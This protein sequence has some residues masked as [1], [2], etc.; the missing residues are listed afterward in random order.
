MAIKKDDNGGFA[1]VDFT[2][3]VLNDEQKKAQAVYIA[4]SRIDP[5]KTQSI[6]NMAKGNLMSPGVLTSL[7]ALGVAPTSQL[8]KNIAGIDQQTKDVRNA[9]QNAL[10]AQRE[11][12]KFN[13][14]PQGKLWT[15]VK[16]VS[17]GLFAVTGTIGE[18]INAAYRQAAK[19]ITDR[20]V[21]AG[22]LRPVNIFASEKDKEE[23]NRQFLSQTKVGQVL[24][25]ALDNKSLKGIDAGAGF[26]VAEDTGIGKAARDAA[27]ATAKID[28]KNA[29]GEVIGSRPRSFFS[30]APSYILSHGHPDGNVG[31]VVQFVTD[32]AASYYTDPQTARAKVAKL[33]RQA[34]EAA[35]AGAGLKESSKI[36]DDLQ[37][38]QEAEKKVNEARAAALQAEADLKKTEVNSN[39][40]NIDEARKTWSGRNEAKIAATENVARKNRNLV[41]AQTK[42]QAIKDEVAGIKSQLDEISNVAKAPNRLAREE[43]NLA[44]AQKALETAK[45][46]SATGKYPT[47][48]YDIPKLETAVTTAQKTVDDLRATVSAATVPDITKIEELKQSLNAALLRAKLSDKEVKQL[49]IDLQSAKKGARIVAKAE[50]ANLI[51]YGNKLSKSRTAQEIV[52]D[53]AATYETKLKAFAD[54]LESLSGIKSGAKPEVN[55]DSISQ[56]LTN[57]HGSAAIDRLAEI[58]D[59]KQIFRMG[60]GRVS[61]EQAIDIAKA[62]TKEEVLNKLAPYIADASLELGV[63][64]PGFIERTGATMAERTKFATPLVKSL[65]GAGAAVANRMPFHA[66]AAAFYEGLADGFKTQADTAKKYVFD[67]IKR[68]Y[69]TTVRGGALLNIHDT[70][71]LIQHVDDAAQ[72]LKL[73]KSV[74]DKLMERIVNAKSASERGYIATVEFFDAVFKQ[75]EKTLPANVTKEFE[76]VTRQ[77]KESNNKAAS[78]W[79]SRNVNGADIKFIQKGGEKV[80]LHGPHLESE[81]LNST[82]YFPAVGEVNRFLGKLQKYSGLNEAANITDALINDY[83][84]RLQLARPAYIIRNIAEEQL[85]VF[86]TGHISF[87]NNPMVATAMWLGAKEGSAFRKAL[88]RIDNYTHTVI[89]DTFESGSAADDLLDEMAAH[90]LK[91]SYID[92]M[93]KSDGSFDERSLRVLHLKSVRAVGPEHERFWDGIVNQMRILGSDTMARVVAGSTPPSVKAAI[94]AGKSREDAVVE[95]FLSGPGRKDLDILA[96]HHPEETR[97]WL[98]SFDGLKQYLYTGKATVKGVVKDASVMSR[99]METTAGNAN[100]RQLIAF[101]KT[102]IGTAEL[103][104]PTAADSASNSLRNAKAIREGKKALLDEQEKFAKTIKNAFGNVAKHSEDMEVNI[105]DV[106]V[107]VAAPLRILGDKTNNAFNW[108]FDTATAFE[109]NSTMGPEFRQAYWDAIHNVASALDKNAIAKLEAMAKDSLSPLMKNGENIGKSHPVWKALA[110]ASEDGVLSL[111]DAH[112]YADNYARNHVKDLF[113]TANKRRLLFHQLRLIGPFMSA[114]EDTITKWGKIGL[115]NPYQVYNLG[116]AINWLEKPESSAMYRFTDIHD[117]YDP[118]QGFFFTDAQT[119]QRMFW[120]PFAGTIM[121]KIAGVPANANYNGNPIAYAANPMSFNFAL[122]AGSILPGV[123]PGITVPLTALDSFTGII[124][125][126]PLPI[127]KWLFPFGKLDLSQGPLSVALPNNINR[128]ITGLT[129]ED[130]LYSNTYKPI[131]DYIASGGNYNLDDVND[132]AELLK[133]TDK[134]AG[135]LSVMRGVVGMF[136]PAALVNKALTHDQNG[137]VTTQIALYNDFRTML[138]ANNNDYNTTVHDFLDLYGANAVFSIISGTSG[139]GPDNWDSYQF[140]VQNP[141]VATKYSDVWGYVYPGGGFS[142]EMYKWNTLNKTKGKLSAQ[143]ILDKANNLRYYAAKDGIIKMVDAGKLDKAGY[144][145]A[146]Q[147]LNNAFNGGPKGAFDPKKFSREMA[148]MRALVQDPRFLDAPSIQ[149]LR[150]YLYLRDAA[151]NKIGVNPANPFKGTGDNAKWAK[152]WLSGQVNTLLRDNPDFYKFYYQFFAKELEG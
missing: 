89:G 77:F 66:Q 38:A 17:R 7:S 111:E 30:D 150:D 49:T 114:W 59:W 86:G 135:F 85:R 132:Q 14:T 43:S 47:W 97:R 18:T 134:F 27:N 29:K 9:N 12:E 16:G 141:D 103:R 96:N 104:M 79:A 120:V 39:K 62:T 93:A 35:R 45:A 151:L 83:W 10:A 58:T 22:L 94:A 108:F 142:Q 119:G 128:I 33:K 139:K 118:N 1:Q 107:D 15:A 106:N 136:S 123:G 143:E 140:V 124:D 23:Y 50:E 48:M 41:D 84:K 73:D 36:A 147:N 74:T 72:V 148:Q 152:T 6:V 20:G 127:Q 91:N 113:Y 25:Q 11:T 61:V 90:N 75:Y 110:N 101:G 95:Y 80:V 126:L 98:Q 64:K 82:V 137:D 149:A 8:S 122:G 19:D 121:S 5:V 105:P 102:K 71:A 109:K 56:F 60:K 51:E 76:R 4:A 145:Q 87:F 53:K 3:P 146:V 26:F 28:I 112:K 81:M 42:N 67:P 129:G 31:S 115:D 65:T 24:L 40:V 131:M 133:K 52:N 37:K 32:V 117:L 21:V 2:T 144:N 57:G 34:E 100:L 54:A 116:R 44:K 138:E 78:Y 13:S 55:Y 69:T 46:E 63:F 88:Y 125:R 92:M 99:I 70:D 130:A 68:K